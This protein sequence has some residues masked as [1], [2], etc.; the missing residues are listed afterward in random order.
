MRARAFRRFAAPAAALM[1]LLGGCSMDVDMLLQPPVAQGEQQGV[2]A[3]LE[4]YIRDSGKTG[5]RYTLRYPSEG[6]HT[7]AFVLCDDYGTPVG[8]GWQRPSIALAF[9]T[10]SATPDKT[11]VNLLRRDGEEWVSVGDL[12]E[13]GAEILQVA[14]ADLDGDGI[15]EVLTGWDTYNLRDHRLAVLSI[16]DELRVISDD[17][18]Y[19]RMVTGAFDAGRPDRLLLLRIAGADEVTATLTGVEN[20]VFSTIA[21]ARLDGRITQFVGTTPCKLGE[22]LTGLY[23]D[24]SVGGG[25]LVTELLYYDGRTLCAP[26]YDPRTNTT[27]T[28]ARRLGLTVCDIDGD[29]QP[30]IPFPTLLPGYGETEEVPSYGFATSWRNY[31]AASGEWTEKQYTIVNVPDGYIV[32]LS[33][34]RRAGVTTRYDADTRTLSLIQTGGSAAWLRLQCSADPMQ[35]YFAESPGEEIVFSVLYEPTGDRP[36]LAAWFDEDVLDIAQVRY[37]VSRI[38]PDMNIQQIQNLTPAAQTVHR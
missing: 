31:S 23:V 32:T 29:G 2:Q 22:R 17:R 4:T 20:D 35:E 11:H 3:A 36:G 34:E 26:F 5:A 28:T 7:S 37:M 21:A 16:A 15:Q 30:E 1:L 33:P 27:P 38:D 14:F 8:G 25:S 6:E 9:Y 24:A 18:M 13:L 12:G 19:S 10:L